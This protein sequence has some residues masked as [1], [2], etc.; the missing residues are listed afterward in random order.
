MKSELSVR[1]QSLREEEKWGRVLSEKSQG[2]GTS[3]NQTYKLLDKARLSI[4]ILSKLITGEVSNKLLQ[5]KVRTPD[6][7][8]AYRDLTGDLF[9][10]WAPEG[11]L[12]GIIFPCKAIALFQIHIIPSISELI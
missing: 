2:S 5:W 8:V 7:H 3:G 4:W 9:M 6:F 1:S 12:N 11:I 10:Y